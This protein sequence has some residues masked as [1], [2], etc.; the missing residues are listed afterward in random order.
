MKTL[1]SIALFALLPAMAIAQR[2]SI[3]SSNKYNSAAMR[4]SDKE[5][6]KALTEKVNGQRP[7]QPAKPKPKSGKQVLQGPTENGNRFKSTK[8]ANKPQ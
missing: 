6:Q 2:E 4:V 8:P 7:D 5:K 3:K 1:F